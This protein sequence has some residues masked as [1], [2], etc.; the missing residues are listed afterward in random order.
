MKVFGDNF[1]NKFLVVK[2]PDQALVNLI[3]TQSHKKPDVIVIVRELVLLLLKA[4]TQL[5]V[6]L[7]EQNPNVLA[8]SLLNNKD[9]E[10]C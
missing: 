7:I 10:R 9:P 4:N 2:S 3:N 6:V 1:N 5:S 8:F